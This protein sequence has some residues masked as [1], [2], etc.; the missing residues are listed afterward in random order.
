VGNVQERLKE[1]GSLLLTMA[2]IGLMYFNMF[3]VPV[4][5]G[6][7]IVY[8]NLPGWVAFAAGSVYLFIFIGYCVNKGLHHG[9]KRSK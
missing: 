5:I 7:Q 6:E 3:V 2:F 1:V 8:R 4:Y 9:T